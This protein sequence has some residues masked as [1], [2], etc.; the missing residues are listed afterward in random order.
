MDSEYIEARNQTHWR[1][2]YSS[3]SRPLDSPIADA[4]DIAIKTVAT[5]LKDNAQSELTNVVFCTF[6][7]DDMAVYED[8]LPHFIPDDAQ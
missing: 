6:S 3:D 7:A 1:T 2:R 5:F 8:R 4:T